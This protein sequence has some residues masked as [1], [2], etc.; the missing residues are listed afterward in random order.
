MPLRTPRGIDDQG[1]ERD[2]VRSPR[3]QTALITNLP[4]ERNSNDQAQA[5]LLI[6]IRTWASRRPLSPS[7]I[8]S[9]FLMDF[10]S[11]HLPRGRRMLHP[12]PSPNQFA[13]SQH[14][15]SAAPEQSRSPFCHA[16][17][18]RSITDQSTRIHHLDTTSGPQHR[19]RPS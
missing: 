17:P 2:P 6:P 9:P 16:Q 18:L 19:G 14:F 15:P 12:S 5:R 8:L 10:V 11:T 7:P 4:K 1:R 13:S 3:Q